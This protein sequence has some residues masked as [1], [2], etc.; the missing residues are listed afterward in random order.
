[1]AVIINRPFMNG[2]YFGR[3]GG[4]E[5]PEWAAEFDCVAWS[6]FSIKYA[7]AHPA[8]TCVLTETTNPEH[9]DENIQAA[10]G[11]LPDE[12]TKRRMSELVQT[13]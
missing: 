12:A 3:V 7:L 5:L 6:Q 2:T 8:V 9:M 11:R 1:M 4:H 13:F 10:F